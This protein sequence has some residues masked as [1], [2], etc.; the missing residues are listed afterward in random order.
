MMSESYAIIQ[1]LQVS[2]SRAQED[3]KYWER[4]ANRWRF[5][6]ESYFKLWYTDIQGGIPATKEQADHE[7]ILF[8][9][10]NFEDN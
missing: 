2:L 10:E 1:D 7:M 8:Y 3:L 9:K 6:A 4:E 5:A